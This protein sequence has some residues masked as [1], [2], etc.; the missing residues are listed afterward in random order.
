[1]C[2]FIETK[3]AQDF[4]IVHVLLIHGDRDLPAPVESKNEIPF[5]GEACLK[6]HKKFCHSLTKILEKTRKKR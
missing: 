4:F 2:V 3:R 1:M 5:R 6:D